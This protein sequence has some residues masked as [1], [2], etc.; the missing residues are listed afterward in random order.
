MTIKYCP[1]CGNK[2]SEI[3]K[4]CDNC[5]YEIATLDDDSSEKLSNNHLIIAT[6]SK[7]L[8]NLIIDYLGAYC[9]TYLIGYVLGLSNVISG[10]ESDEFYSFMG[11]IIWGLYYMIFELLFSGKTLGKLITRTRVVVNDGKVLTLKHVF[12]RTLIRFIPFEA[13]SFLSTKSNQGRSIGWHDTWSNTLVIE[14]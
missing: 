6:S 13:L 2:L 3:A 9:F 4:F 12:I 8:F 14:D 10:N 7:R 11:F 5:G 1:N